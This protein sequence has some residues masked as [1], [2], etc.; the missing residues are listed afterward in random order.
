MVAG[1][2]QPIINTSGPIS[3]GDLN[4][5]GKLEIVT[6][7]TNKVT[8]LNN[9]GDTIRSLTI[10]NL[11]PAATPILADIDGDS[12]NEIVFGSTSGL[13]KNIYAFNMDLTKVLGFP[14]KTD[15]TASGVP[16]ISDINGDGK[17]E[18]VLGV[19]AWIYIWKTNGKAGNVEWGCNRQNQYN[20]GVYQKVCTPINIVANET[21][22]TIH[23]FCGD[24]VVKSGTLT[25]NSGA[26]LTMGNL[27]TITIMSGASL[28]IDSGQ[29][30]NANIRAMSGSNVTI[31]NNGSITLRTNA[32]FY[33]ET[34]TN[35]EI[36]YGS[37][38]K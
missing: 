12:D 17:N 8:V 3:V 1:W 24:L 33:T 30:L 35:L 10:P 14:L 16:S 18:I 6:L 34:G 9:K 37:I 7:G 38:D 20:T 19:D 2:N 11:S 22:N 13:N 31:T 5:D 21:W 23:S 27:T 25:I 4:H 29:I 28:V 15:L 32:E 36:Q 26:T